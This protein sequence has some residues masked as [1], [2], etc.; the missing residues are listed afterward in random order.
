M[1]FKVELI[2]Y[3]LFIHFDRY[4]SARLEGLG[5]SRFSE[6][7]NKSKQALL[8]ILEQLQRHKHIKGG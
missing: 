4:L 7:L 5:L 3:I 1:L 8:W 6:H 2:L